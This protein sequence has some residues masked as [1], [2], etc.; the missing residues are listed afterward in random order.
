MSAGNQRAKGEGSLFKSPSTGRW[1]AKIDLPPD[2]VTGKRRRARV[3]GRTQKEAAEKLRVLRAKVDGGAFAPEAR[4]T[5][6][7][8]LDRW[9]DDM[10]PG[11]VKPGTARTTRAS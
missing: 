3:T 7:G 2:P 10:L 9:L 4:L 6:G 8:F 1:E 5:I 11:T